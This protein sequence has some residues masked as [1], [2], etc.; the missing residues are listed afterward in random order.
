MHMTLL[1]LLTQ[2]VQVAAVERM[3][4]DIDDLPQQFQSAEIVYL[5]KNC[6]NHLE[7]CSFDGR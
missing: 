6:L 4:T 1:T 3:L 7:V 2:P 5:S